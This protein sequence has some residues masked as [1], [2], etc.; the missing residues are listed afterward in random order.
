MRIY[1]LDACESTVVR[2]RHRHGNVASGEAVVV[3][4]IIASRPTR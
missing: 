2:H 3:Y 4:V 1:E